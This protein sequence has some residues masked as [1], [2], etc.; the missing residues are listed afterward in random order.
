MAKKKTKELQS[1]LPTIEEVSTPAVTEQAAAPTVAADLTDLVAA[2]RAQIIQELKASGVNV[3]DPEETQ[4]RMEHEKQTYEEYVAAMKKS[5]V[6]WVDL[7]GISE[8][9]QGIRIEL[10]WNDAFIQELRNSGI[11]GADDEAVAQKW[12][13]LLSRDLDESS[14]L[15][16]DATAKSEYV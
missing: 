9:G 5:P 8:A 1:S 12:L 13:A 11:T 6:G 16:E 15:E 3:P 4:K 7:R 2:L 10:D 14:A